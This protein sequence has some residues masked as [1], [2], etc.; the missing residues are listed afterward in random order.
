MKKKKKIIYPPP[1]RLVSSFSNRVQQAF[2][3][4][5]VWFVISNLTAN[6]KFFYID[7]QFGFCLFEKIFIKFYIKKLDWILNWTNSLSKCCRFG[8][9][10]FFLKF[11]LMDQFLERNKIISWWWW[12]LIYHHKSSNFNK[13][14]NWL[15][16]YA[17]WCSWW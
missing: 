6:Q 7:V 2:F 16:Y 8:N 13:L 15:L 5:F 3:G 1:H 12:F 14:P 10:V 17:Y 9:F 4:L 11:C